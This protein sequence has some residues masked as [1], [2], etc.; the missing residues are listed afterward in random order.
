MHSTEW[1]QV[2]EKSQWTVSVGDT[3]FSVLSPHQAI[4]A[5]EW[6]GFLCLRP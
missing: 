1:L 4:L 2:G 6:L 3:L 5:L